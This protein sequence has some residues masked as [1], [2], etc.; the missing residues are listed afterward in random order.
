MRGLESKQSLDVVRD[1]GVFEIYKDI[2][3]NSIFGTL[4]VRSQNNCFKV[5]KC[6]DGAIM[7]V[8][9]RHMTRPRVSVLHFYLFANQ[10]SA[11]FCM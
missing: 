4:Y 2:I 11:I 3:F 8:C 1:L 9:M 5:L 7:S 10:Q 6:P